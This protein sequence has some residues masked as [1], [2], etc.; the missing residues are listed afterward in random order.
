MEKKNNKITHFVVDK[1]NVLL[2]YGGIELMSVFNMREIP[3]LKALMSFL[4]IF[5]KGNVTFQV[6]EIKEYLLDYIETDDYTAL[7]SIDKN[8]QIV[9]QTAIKDE[10]RISS[11][12]QYRCTSY[13]ELYPGIYVFKNKNGY[14]SMINAKT[15]Q[16]TRSFQFVFNDITLEDVNSEDSR[17]IAKIP[18]Q[19]EG[20]G[21]NLEDVITCTLDR[22]LMYAVKTYSELQNRY[23]ENR[24]TYGIVEAKKYLRELAE[25]DKLGWLKSR[26]ELEG[27]EPSTGSLALKDH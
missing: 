19:V 13:Y 20:N 3:G 1:H 26:E 24:D 23:L 2:A 5:K 11:Y 6:E 18:I 9:F 15:D 22:N 25:L 21:R 17:I 8:R 14:V 4:R 16:G 12:S 7:V 27:E 10:Y